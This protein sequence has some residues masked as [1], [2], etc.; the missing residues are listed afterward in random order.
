MGMFDTWAPSGKTTA[1]IIIG[2]IVW[3]LFVAIIAAIVS[4]L[5]ILY[6]FGPVFGWSL[7]LLIVFVLIGWF[8]A[9]GGSSKSGSYTTC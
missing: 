4:D 6:G 5:V 2:I 8:I 7:A 1:E 3:I 9:S